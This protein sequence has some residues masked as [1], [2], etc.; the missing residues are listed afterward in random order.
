MQ[1]AIHLTVFIRYTIPGAYIKINK[2]GR[3][4]EKKY[5]KM[6]ILKINEMYIYLAASHKENEEKKSWL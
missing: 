1:H 6:Y 2:K 4:G 3:I 5:K